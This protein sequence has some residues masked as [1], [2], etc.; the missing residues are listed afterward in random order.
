MNLKSVQF[1]LQLRLQEANAS[2]DPRREHSRFKD[3]HLSV[4]FIFSIVIISVE[5]KLNLRLQRLFF[6]SIQTTCHPGTLQLDVRACDDPRGRSQEVAA[7]SAAEDDVRSLG[8]VLGDEETEASQD[9][10][11]MMKKMTDSSTTA[12]SETH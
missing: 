11:A 2:E 4:I 1:K 7:E 8:D 3:Y 5:A 10:D 6:S 9:C 12:W